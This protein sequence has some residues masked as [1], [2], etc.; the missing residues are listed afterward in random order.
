[1]VF[2]EFNGV[3]SYT[4]GSVLEYTVILIELVVSLVK[5]FVHTPNLIIIESPDAILSFAFAVNTIESDGAV[6]TAG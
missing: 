3:A 1:M 4:V 6:F 5:S 2:N